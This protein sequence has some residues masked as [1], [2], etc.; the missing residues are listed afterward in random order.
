MVEISVILPVYNGIKYIQNSVE[1]VLNQGFRNFEFIILDDCSSDGSWEYLQSLDDPRIRLFRNEINRG[2]FYGLNFMIRNCQAPIIKIWS[3][4]DVLYPNCIAEV[5]AFHQ[6]HP[7][8]GF[9]YSNRDYIDAHG[10]KMVIL[11]ED[12]TPEIVSTELHSHIAFITGSIAGNIANVAINKWALDE[13]GLFNE[14]MKIS[15]DF[16]MWVRLAKD[17]P[18]G[19]IHKKLLQ[20]R[21]HKE[22]LS[23]QEKYFIYHLKE[24]IQAYKILFGYISKKQKE[25]GK[26][27]LREKKLMFYYTL[28]IKAVLKGRLKTALNFL[29]LLSGFDNILILTY[30]FF[31]QKLIN[32]KS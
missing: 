13:V 6:Q 24:D 17:H 22:Q 23:G 26:K 28:M 27:L 4:D 30:C 20:L 2:L 21:N 8:I 19:F 7:Q 25:Q 10:K 1:S 14:K 16:E 15:G 5:I 3:Q 18:I 29:N 31:I 9:S 32:K 11:K 12:T